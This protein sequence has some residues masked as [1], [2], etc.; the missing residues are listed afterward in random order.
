MFILLFC[1]KALAASV[2]R[3]NDRKI[4]EIRQV[5]P[6]EAPTPSKAV[7]PDG[8]HVTK[9][10]QAKVRKFAAKATFL[11]TTKRNAG[12]AGAVTIDKYATTLQ[13]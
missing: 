9:L 13:A 2:R 3:V 8:L 12:I 5:P 11:H 1:I 4:A 10:M 6:A 7:F